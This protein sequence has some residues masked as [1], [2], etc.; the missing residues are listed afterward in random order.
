MHWEYDFRTLEE[1]EAPLG[2]D[3][4]A[5]SLVVRREREAKYVHFAGLPPLLFDLARDPHETVDR[6]DD[7]DYAPM[8]LRMAEALLSW[9]A[10]HLERR[11]TGMLL[12]DS[13]PL[14]APR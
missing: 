12:T 13:G 10:R 3:R 1:A 4:D 5:C 14:G 2:L 6:A 9:R 8:R 11:F 7:P